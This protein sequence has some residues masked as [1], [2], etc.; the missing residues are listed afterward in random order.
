M[1]T[2]GNTKI[3][4]RDQIQFSSSQGEEVSIWA[5]YVTFQVGVG[6][7]DTDSLNTLH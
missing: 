1:Y 7:S 2:E 3:T 4:R 5:R 6:E